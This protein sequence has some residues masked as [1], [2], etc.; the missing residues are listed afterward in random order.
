VRAL[1]PA[2]LVFAEAKDQ[3]ELLVAVLAK[4]FVLRHGDLLEGLQ[5]VF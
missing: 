4:E 1:K 2:L 5:L 3:R